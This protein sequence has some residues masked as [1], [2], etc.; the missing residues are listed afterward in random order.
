MDEVDDDDD[1]V[2][3]DE[4]HDDDEALE[5]GESACA[6]PVEELNDEMGELD[7]EPE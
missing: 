2:G 7:G 6:G 4:I 3:D 5:V 1:D